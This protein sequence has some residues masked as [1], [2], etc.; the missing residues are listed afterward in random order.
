M[1]TM[2]RVGS[3]TKMLAVALTGL[4]LGVLGWA[5]TASGQTEIPKSRMRATAK[6]N[7]SDW[8]GWKAIDGG[9]TEQSKWWA[10]ASGDKAAWLRIELDT[11]YRVTRLDQRQGQSNIRMKDFRVYVTDS[12]STDEAD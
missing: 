4:L 5:P 7:Y 9:E 6:S 11:R 1:K 8:Y 2:Q 10:S 12:T 3:G